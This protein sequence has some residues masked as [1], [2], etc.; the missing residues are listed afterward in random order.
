M[1]AVQILRDDPCSPDFNPQAEALRAWE[2]RRSDPKESHR[3]AMDLIDHALEFD[4]PLVTAWAYL[5]CGA[6]ELAGKEFEE[7]EESLAAA[8]KL[9]IR[10]GERRG[11][12][13]SIVLRARVH[14]GRGEFNPALELYKQII[15]REAHGLQTL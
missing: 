12:S 1:S 10:T 8:T 3:L 14:M 15:E 6:H 9:F 2:I 5:T 13:L 7:A 11:E 4:D